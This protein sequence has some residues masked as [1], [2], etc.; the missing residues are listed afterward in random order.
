MGDN[1]DASYDSR[2]WGFLDGDLVLAKAFSVLYTWQHEPT[3]P[4]WTALKFGRS[5]RIL[6]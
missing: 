5:F 4:F 1:W 6:H 3:R 2:N